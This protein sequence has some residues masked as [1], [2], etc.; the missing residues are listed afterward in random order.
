MLEPRIKLASQIKTDSLLDET[1]KSVFMPELTLLERYSEITNNAQSRHQA[2]RIFTNLRDFTDGKIDPWVYSAALLHDV[3]QRLD[4][5]IESKNATS[6]L[7]TYASWVSPEQWEFVSSILSDLRLVEASA[8]T[9]QHDYL[10]KESDDELRSLLHP[11]AE[12]PVP[13]RLWKA[14]SMIANPQHVLELMQDVNI[15]SLL[16]LSARTLDNLNHPA[17]NEAQQLQNVFRAES[18]YAPICEILGYDALAMALRS[19]ASRIRLIKSGNEAFLEVA[20]E[21]ITALGDRDQM[22]SIVSELYA[23]LIGGDSVDEHAI[24]NKG[25]HN[26]V[27]GESLLIDPFKGIEELR[28][29]WRVKSEGSLARKIEQQG[30]KPVDV[31]GITLITNTVNELAVTYWGIVRR[32][33]QSDDIEPKHSASR[34]DA[35]H[36]RGSGKYLSK[37]LSGQGSKQVLESS[38]LDIKRNRTAAGFQVAKLTAEYIRKTEDGEQRIPFE[39]QVQTEKD[40]EKSRVGQASHILYKGREQPSPLEF[41]YRVLQEIK[42]RKQMIGRHIAIDS[43]KERG[44]ALRTRV[45]RS[46]VRLLFTESHSQPVR[47]KS[48]R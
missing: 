43:S 11:N 20:R 13:L 41:D 33:K 10:E 9:T 31:L 3:A 39:I 36:I 45:G 8:D 5:P 27:L 37:V 7:K 28:A 19:E 38:E 40:R 18:F 12:G 48:K 24:S 44:A 15:E 34:D 22:K 2:E 16:L 47:R 35:F 32:L 6:V 25:Q 30:R 26:V 14:P 23:K 42:A 29:V 1:A 4:D 21:E 17:E 46:A